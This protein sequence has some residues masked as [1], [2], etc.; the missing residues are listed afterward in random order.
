MIERQGEYISQDSYITYSSMLTS[1]IPFYETDILS[2]ILNIK[3]EKNLGVVTVVTSL[4]NSEQLLKQE[5]D[6]EK[7][8]NCILPINVYISVNDFCEDEKIKIVQD[9]SIYI[10]GNICNK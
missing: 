9:Y 8:N 6:Y 4:K 1:D 10:K 3:K 5:K 2:E 7:K